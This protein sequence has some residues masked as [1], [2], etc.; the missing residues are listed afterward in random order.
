M[1]KRL[2]KYQKK[3]L[4]GGTAAVAKLFEGIGSFM[5][6]PLAKIEKGINT[7]IG[8]SKKM[9]DKIVEFINF[10]SSRLKKGAKT[11]FAD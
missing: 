7:A 4:T 10:I 1:Q 9:N 2:V 8:T 3:L 6:N 11:L 5:K